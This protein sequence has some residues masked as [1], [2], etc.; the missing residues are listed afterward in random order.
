MTIRYWRF[1]LIQSPA[2]ILKYNKIGQSLGKIALQEFFPNSSSSE[3][4]KDKKT[5]NL[6]T[7]ILSKFVRL[8]FVIIS[9]KA[10]IN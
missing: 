7:S 3:K 4:G 10:P 2:V 8:W 5:F 1:T 6:F 9:S